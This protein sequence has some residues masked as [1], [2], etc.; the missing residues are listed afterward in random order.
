[1]A[2]RVNLHKFNSKSCGKCEHAHE[3]VL[4][5]IDAGICDDMGRRLVFVSILSLIF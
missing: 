5:G 2:I 1:M 4:F 3:N